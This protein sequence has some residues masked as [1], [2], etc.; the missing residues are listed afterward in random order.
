MRSILDPTGASGQD[1]DT[2]LAPRL[3]SP[4]GL[5][6]GLVDNGKPTAAVLLREVG[7]HLKAEHGLAGYRLVTKGY[8]G[9]P[10]EPELVADVAADC[11]L[12]LAAVGD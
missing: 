4:R 1:D 12:V 3:P 6:A 9:T 2:T 11:D 8:F 5:R 7:D 10:A